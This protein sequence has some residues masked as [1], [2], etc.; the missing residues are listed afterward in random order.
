MRFEPFFLV[1]MRRVVAVEVQAAFA[2]RHNLGLLRHYPQRGDRR[3]VAVA[4]VV[5]VNT[6]SAID[7]FM[8]FR[9]RQRGST[10]MYRSP[11][12]D[13]IFHAR[14]PRSIQNLL[15]VGMKGRMRKIRPD[16]NE[17]HAARSIL[18]R[19]AE[20]GRHVRISDCRG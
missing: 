9:K 5:R 8:V 3:P 6:C 14:S 17:L 16:I 15:K 11:G 1:R 19:H 20:P 10:F 18:A 13:D 12:H 7:T 2:D 4:R